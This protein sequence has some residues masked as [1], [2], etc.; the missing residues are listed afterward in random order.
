MEISTALSSWAAACC[1]S[2]QSRRTENEWL[3]PSGDFFF[4][5]QSRDIEFQQPIALATEQFGSRSVR[6]KQ[7]YFNFYTSHYNGTAYFCTTASI[8]LKWASLHAVNISFKSVQI[9]WEGGSFFL[10][11]VYL[12]FLLTFLAITC[13]SRDKKVGNF[14]E[15]YYINRKPTAKSSLLEILLLC[16]SQF[17]WNYNDKLRAEARAFVWLNMVATNRNDHV[18]IRLRYTSYI[19]Q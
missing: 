3:F 2:W 1:R 12:L 10:D 13:I 6:F 17:G 18:L 14:I 11:T 7:C 9:F 5:F 8:C 15:T 19:G 16:L 4:T